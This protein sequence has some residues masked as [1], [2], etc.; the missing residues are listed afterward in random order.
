MTTAHTIGTTH[1]HAPKNL[2]HKSRSDLSKG[3]DQ[4]HCGERRLELGSAL[5]DEGT[6]IG[7]LLHYQAIE[8]WHR[9][10]G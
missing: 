7:G 4:E 1:L 8:I 3:A 10:P 9:L 6:C 5:Q 2:K